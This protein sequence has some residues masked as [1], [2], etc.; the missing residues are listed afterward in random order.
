M[1]PN[2]IQRDVM[3]KSYIAHE[4]MPYENMLFINAAATCPCSGGTDHLNWSGGVGRSFF[5]KV[6]IVGT[7]SAWMEPADG[8]FPL[9]VSMPHPAAIKTAVRRRMII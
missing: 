6:L 7:G 5:V 8:L 2:F 4:I 9:S 1:A 3:L